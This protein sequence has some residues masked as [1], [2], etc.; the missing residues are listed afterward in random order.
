MF[1]N[2]NVFESHKTGK[3][4]QKAVQSDSISEKRIQKIKTIAYL[5]TWLMKMVDLMSDKIKA[6]QNQVR[7][8]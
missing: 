5:E 2:K 3:K 8:K 1:S 7:K 6:T 4:H